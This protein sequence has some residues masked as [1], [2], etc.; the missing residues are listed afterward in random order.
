MSSREQLP[1]AS[2]LTESINIDGTSLLL[3]VCSGPSSSVTSLVY[4]STF[5]VVFGCDEIIG[6]DENLPYF[7]LHRHWDNY[8]ISKSVAERL[9]L[10]S[11]GKNKKFHTCSLRLAG[12]MGVGETRHLPR[13]VASLPF[14]KFRYGNAKVQFVGIKNAVQAHVKALEKLHDDPDVV[15]GEAYFISDGKPI[16]H[17]EYFRP[18]IEGLGYTYPKWVL[19]VGL[20][21]IFVLLG[22]FFLRVFGEIWG[23]GRGLF[24]SPAELLKT[25]VTHW[26]S[27]D[28]AKQH[29]G[30]APEDVN[31]LSGVL[32]EYRRKMGLSPLLKFRKNDT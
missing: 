17:W 24:L 27:I 23:A 30:Y 32:H 8:S 9:V 10:A 3:K 22:Q 6:G 7:P 15:G 20:M 29:F 14:L 25:S 11:S 1:S 18:L 2:S 28:K 21:W 16:E 12:V 26:F 13:I 31:D 4:T 5:N 19:P